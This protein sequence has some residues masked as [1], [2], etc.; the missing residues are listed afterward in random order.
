[1]M[2]HRLS[3]AFGVLRFDRAQHCAMLF[4]RLIPGRL[5]VKIIRKPGK[6]NARARIK[7]LFDQAC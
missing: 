4:D 7:H 2:P 6:K 1:M 5:G 3:R